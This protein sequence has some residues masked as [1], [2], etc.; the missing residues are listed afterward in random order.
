MSRTVPEWIGAS[1]DAAIPPRVRLRVF[2]RHD[3]KCQC[4][5][6]RKI[7]IG[8]PWQCDHIVALVNGGAHRETNLHP[9][10][11]EHHKNKTRADVA[12][13][14]AT[15]KRRLRHLGIKRKRSSFQTNRDAPFK[16]KMNGEVVRRT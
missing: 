9:M 4:G 11:A 5:C 6:R 15:Y 14:A 16:K 8:E 2:D 1:P 10:L 3:G 13:K 7:Q 12:L